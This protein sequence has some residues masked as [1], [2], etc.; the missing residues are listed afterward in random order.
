VMTLEPGLYGLPTGG[1]RVEHDYL[2]TAEG[3]ERLSNHRL[4]LG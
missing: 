4:G 1:I 3:H 2:I